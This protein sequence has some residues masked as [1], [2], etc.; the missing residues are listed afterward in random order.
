MT[1]DPATKMR[2]RPTRREPPSTQA[3]A[4]DFQRDQPCHVMYHS[5]ARAPVRRPG[6]PPLRVGETLG[7]RPERPRPLLDPLGEGFSTLTHSSP[8]Q[9]GQQYTF[10]AA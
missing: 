5:A 10:R 9:K 7:E 8:R 3:G 6:G 4:I 1:A 2:R